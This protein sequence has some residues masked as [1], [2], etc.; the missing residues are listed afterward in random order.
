MRPPPSVVA[1]MDSENEPKG[2]FLILDGCD[3]NVNSRTMA[4]V[5]LALMSAYYVFALEYP[6]LYSQALEHCPYVCG[7]WHA[8]Q[9][10]PKDIW[11][12]RIS[13]AGNQTA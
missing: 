6:K 1:F 7:T 4:C 8:V 5:V 3:I 11:V 9:W 10:R 2:Q 12:Q 13:E